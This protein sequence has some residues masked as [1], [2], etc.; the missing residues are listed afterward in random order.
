VTTGLATTHLLT[1]PP[2]VF[3][4]YLAAARGERSRGIGSE[5]FRFSWDCGKSR[6]QAQGLRPLGLIWEI[7]PLRPD[8]DDA[9]ARQRRVDFFRRQG[10]R[11]LEREYLQ[12]PVNGITP[13]PMTLM[14]RPDDGEALPAEATVDE[15][16]RAIYFDKYGT[17]NGIDR[18]LLEDLL[19][20]R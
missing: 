6:L 4:I 9:A 10:G 19:G 3:L 12:P 17:V 1:H 8:A 18:S 13:V 14:F 7:D 5:L 15:L 11:V 16:V 20:R 2:A